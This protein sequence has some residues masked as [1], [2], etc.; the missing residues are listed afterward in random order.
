MC[1]SL[2]EDL[3]PKIKCCFDQNFAK[4]RDNRLSMPLHA[5]S[6]KNSKAKEVNLISDQRVFSSLTKLSIL[7]LKWSRQ[8]WSSQ[9]KLYIRYVIS[10]SVFCVL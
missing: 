7:C 8:G 10:T 2:D 9:K 6:E 1:R 5:C 3:I 4:E